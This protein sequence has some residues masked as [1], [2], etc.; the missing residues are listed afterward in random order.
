MSASTI[1]VGVDGSAESDHAL[2]WAA[3]Y[4]KRTAA[5][6]HVVSS[7]TLPGFFLPLD[8]EGRRIV[9]DD[10]R[11]RTHVERT[12]AQA[13]E[14]A[15]RAGVEA[16]TEVATGDPT[17]VLVERSG[18]HALA[19][20]GARGHGGFAERLL[21]TV[22]AT[23]PAYARCPTV[24]V[25]FRE[26]HGGAPE[27]ASDARPGDGP[28]ADTVRRFGRV[29]VGVDGS[30]GSDAAMAEGAAQARALA[31]E[32]LVV[33]AL[34]ADRWTH[35][36]WTPVPPD[37]EAL[38]AAAGDELASRVAPVRASAPELSITARAMD[39]GAPRAL[40]ELSE[41]ADLVVVGSRGR[42]GF[43]GLLLGS[44]SQAVLRSAHCPVLVV[45]TS[46]D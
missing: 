13:A 41:S 12:V 1:L 30:P 28:T 37:R 10:V 17:G 43:R 14:R 36:P 2:D 22:S 21:G 39:G 25:P 32:L 8:E 15:A 19:V 44:T 3:A 20:V 40:A 23:L 4:A 27:A 11:V 42:G 46:T 9:P 29:V 45:G 33:H 26:G 24:V 6:L 38:L 31:A 5:A 18:D 34:A 7:Y 35:L 16:T